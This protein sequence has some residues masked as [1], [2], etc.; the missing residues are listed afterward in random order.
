MA[1]VF[2]FFLAW[3]CCVVI[4]YNLLDDAFF[5][6]FSSFGQGQLKSFGLGSLV[7]AQ[8]AQYASRTWA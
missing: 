1:H 7:I 8:Q 5:F 4:N 3:L 6:F 2:C